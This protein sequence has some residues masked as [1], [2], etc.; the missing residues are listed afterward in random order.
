MKPQ[1]RIRSA[2]L[3]PAGSVGA[4][5]LADISTVAPRPRAVQE[6]TFCNRSLFFSSFTRNKHINVG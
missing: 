3:S 2:A 6:I 4:S 5:G 1:E